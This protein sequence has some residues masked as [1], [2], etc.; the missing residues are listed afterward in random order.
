M[1]KRVSCQATRAGDFGRPYRAR[2]RVGRNGQPAQVAD[3]SAGTM[4]LRPGNLPYRP[5]DQSRGQ[6]G[7]LGGRI[8]MTWDRVAAMIPLKS[9]REV[10]DDPDRAM[11]S[12]QAERHSRARTD[13]QRATARRGR[14]AEAMTRIGAVAASLAIPVEFQSAFIG[15]M[16]SSLPSPGPTHWRF[17]QRPSVHGAGPLHI[18]RPARGYPSPWWRARGNPPSLRAILSG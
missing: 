12:A 16:I 17:S 1:V 7:L 18:G 5:C 9:V 13:S 11:L 3:C 2:P 6:H 15:H 10:A 8:R 4:P 14:R